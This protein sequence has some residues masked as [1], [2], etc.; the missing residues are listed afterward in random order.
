M[1]EMREG[2]GARMMAEFTCPKCGNYFLGLACHGCVVNVKGYICSRCGERIPN[3]FWHGEYHQWLKTDWVN[4]WN[5]EGAFVQE[6]S[7]DALPQM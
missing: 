4:E 5:R 7:V 2:V 3:P 6:V 1:P